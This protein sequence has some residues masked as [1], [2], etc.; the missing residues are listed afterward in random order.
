MGI[1]DWGRRLLCDH[2]VGLSPKAFLDSLRR[3]HYEFVARE[4]NRSSRHK[5]SSVGLPDSPRDFEDLVTL[6]ELSSLNRGVIRQDFDEA[7][8]LFRTVRSLPAPRGVEIGRA[9]GGST[10]LLAVAV[11]P[12][13]KLLS[14][15][16]APPDDGLLVEVLN[17]AHLLDRVEL[18]VGDANRFERNEQFDFVLIDGDHTY[19]GA[20]KD[21]NRWGKL[22]RPGGFVVHHDMGNSRNLATPLAELARL[23]QDIL[24][25]QREQLELLAEA[26]SMVVF[27][28]RS[29]SWV[30]V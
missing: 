16:L 30:G 27:R 11:G 12:G 15:D 22:V 20:R 4:F 9:A 21:H 19:E 6:F 8:L 2:L 25:R 29:S 24:T 14:I 3:N 7:A 26:G 1:V 18:V 17:R 10:L 23:R 13:G 5:W 28:R